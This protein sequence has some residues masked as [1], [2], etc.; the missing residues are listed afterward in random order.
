MSLGSGKPNF[1]NRA[2]MATVQPL[3]PGSPGR[4]LTRRL[5][6]YQLLER[7]S[8]DE[9]RRL[10]WQAL[11]RLLQHA[12]D[13]TPFYR[14]RFDRIGLKPSDVRS[15]HELAKIPPLTRE[16]I[17]SHFEEL[18]S[19]NY[20][21]ESLRSAATGGTTDTPVPLLRSPECLQEKMAVQAHFDTW[22]GMWP[23]DKVFR[24]WGAQQ[25]FSPNPSWR[26]RVYDRHVLRNV[27]APTSLLNPIILE[28]YRL[29][30]NEFRPKIIYAYPTPLALFCEYLNDCGR[31]Y[32]R[33]RSA[34]CTAEP[35]QEEQRKVIEQALGCPVF[36]HYG[37]RDFGMVAAE[38]ET[39]EGMH[40]N[41]AAVF[42]EYIPIEGAETEGLHE[43]LVTDLLNRGM[44]MIRYRINDCATLAERPCSCGRTFPLIRGIV[45]RTT[46]NFR[47]PSGSIVPG[48]A[49]TNRVIQTCPGLKKVQVI[50]KTLE[51]FHVRFVPGEG[52]ARAD[53][54]QLASKLRVFFPDPL[55]WTFEQV[56]EIERERSGKTRFCI[57]LVRTP[58][59]KDKKRDGTVA[60]Q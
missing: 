31:P 21:K 32:F 19:R 20:R 3:M 16:E 51:D 27:W 18:W 40:F 24:L 48:V 47:L 37:T 53:L 11:S 29:L 41:P 39:H 2:Y 14:E 43:I 45:G 8:A 34:I 10:Q 46:D 52:F 59:C 36:Q 12:Y 22:A 56:S 54:D 58:E 33:P 13:F 30:L 50:Q 44:P 38:C 5:G 25:D 17:R 23:G 6:E 49:L 55:H 57:S 9:N 1:F 28:K 26:W 35:L 60:R 15:E 7:L 4:G 42:V